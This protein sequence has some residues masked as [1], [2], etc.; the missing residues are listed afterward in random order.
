MGTTSNQRIKIGIQEDEI[1]TIEEAAFNII[2]L[3]TVPAMP[4]V[5]KIMRDLH[6][7]C[8]NHQGKKEILEIPKKVDP[9]LP[10]EEQFND[11]EQ[12]QP[13]S[14]EEVD[15]KWSA[16]N[17]EPITFHLKRAEKNLT[18]KKVRETPIELLDVAL[19]KLT[20]DDM[21]LSAISIN[22][23]DKAREL[24]VDIRKE[25][26][27]LEHEIYDQKKNLGDLVGNG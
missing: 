20:H 13:L 25:A 15:V 17:I 10:D 5:H 11:S 19:K 2:R 24:I 14:R 6:K 3:R 18:S 21:D 8:D 7:Y 9:L 27:Q 12:Q 26:I 1:G 4:K 23:Y 22:D 16:K